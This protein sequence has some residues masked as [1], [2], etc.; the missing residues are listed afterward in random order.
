[1]CLQSLLTIKQTLSTRPETSKNVLTHM[2]IGW[3]SGP[4]FS[5]GMG[6]FTSL[7]L[8]FP[9]KPKVN[10]ITAEFSLLFGRN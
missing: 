10:V 2:K 1:M 5:C 3:S 9:V 7:N 8:S 4:Q 6:S